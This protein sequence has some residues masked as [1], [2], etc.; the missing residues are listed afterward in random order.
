MSFGFGIHVCP[1]QPLAKAEMR[2]AVT[3]L[4]RRLPAFRINGKVERTEPL[5]GGGRHLGVRK[6]PVAW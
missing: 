5:E 4:L 6:L 1:G 3:T 2:I